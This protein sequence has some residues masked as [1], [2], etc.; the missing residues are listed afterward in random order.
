MY[1]S[2]GLLINIF[3]TSGLLIQ[4]Y[5]SNLTHSSCW[6][7]GFTKGDSTLGDIAGR[8]FHH[9]N[10]IRN[11]ADRNT[12]ST[13]CAVIG[14]ERLMGLR[15]EVD[16]LVPGVIA[17]HVA[18]TTVDAHVIVDSG[19]NLFSVVKLVVA[20]DAGECLTDDAVHCRHLGNGGR[21]DSGCDG[22]VNAGRKLFLVEHPALLGLFTK[23]G[24]RSGDEGL[25]EGHN[26]LLVVPAGKV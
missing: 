4:S 20:A 11:R 22:Q 7:L 13:S 19:N 16:G 14:D 21:L 25:L 12:E 9:R 2:W 10:T 3:F 18:L 8:T 24:N 6:E 15:V 23:F 26:R 17:R 1:I 5:I